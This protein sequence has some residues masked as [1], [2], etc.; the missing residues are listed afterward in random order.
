MARP[1][2]YSHATKQSQN[3]IACEPEYKC[4]I[5]IYYKEVNAMSR[6]IGDR[7]SFDADL[8]I[9][10]DQLDVEWLR[11]PRLYMK[12]SELAEQADAELRRAKEALAVCY[13]QLYAKVMKEYD[14]KPSDTLI[15][16]QVIVQKEYRDAKEVVESA[17]YH[18]NVLAAAVKS[19]GQRKDALEGLVKLWQG[20]YFAGPREPRSTDAMKKLIEQRVDSAD[21]RQ[22]DALNRKKSNKGE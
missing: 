6:Y 18:A 8:Y 17:T 21:Q 2:S 16:S 13:A 11:Q 10:I 1:G 15:D 7:T 22:R 19:M 5:I 4:I 9:D 3:K 20:Q 12:Y 14:K